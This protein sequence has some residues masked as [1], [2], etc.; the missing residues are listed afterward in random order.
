MW[1]FKKKRKIRGA[2]IEIDFDNRDRIAF[3]NNP[4]F[5]ISDIKLTIH[6]D[7]GGISWG[8]DRIV[9]V[10]VKDHR[11]RLIGNIYPNLHKDENKIEEVTED[12]ED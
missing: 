11:G 7:L 10:T 3:E 6:H 9:C 12:G 4:S 1:L 5:L 8:I 2:R